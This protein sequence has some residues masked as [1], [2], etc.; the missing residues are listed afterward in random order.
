MKMQRAQMASPRGYRVWIATLAVAFLTVVLLPLAQAAPGSGY[1]LD[2]VKQ[3]GKLTL[4]YRVD[5]RPFSFRD[6]S[7]NAAGYAVALCQKVAE[8]VKA[9]IGLPTLTVVWVP[10]TLEG[11]FS[12]VEEGKIDL[13]CGADTASL[14]RRKEISF[15]IPI[16]PG[17]IG[18]LLRADSSWRLREILTK[19]QA[20]SRPIW[21]ASPAEVLQ[22]QVFAV[23]RGATS[24]G[25]L[26]GRLDKFQLD[27][28]VIPVDGYDAGIQGVLDRRASVFFA[29]RPILVEAAKRS[30]AAKE[31][32]V[33]DRLFTYEPLALALKRGDEDFRLVVDRTLSRVYRMEDFGFLYTKWFG[34]PGEDAMNFFRLSAL[35]D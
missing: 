19:G 6:E 2:R 3:S 7:G 31:L 15:S 12:A 33:L 35:P 22:K 14:A 34:K 28:K 8:Q 9:E 13:L 20:A 25:W 27:A 11:R 21:R 26:A 29:D 18:A 10:V 17:G 30:S 23:V 24:E 5:A 16:F 1:T 32:I 4:G